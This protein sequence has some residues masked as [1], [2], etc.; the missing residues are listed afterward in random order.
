ML[1]LGSLGAVTGAVE[2]VYE[3]FGDDRLTNIA[4][5]A[6]VGSILGGGFGALAARQARKA[7]R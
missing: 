7:D 5:G 6:G 3:E 1:Q 2:P 4:I